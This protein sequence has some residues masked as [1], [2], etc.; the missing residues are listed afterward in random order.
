M[1]I[2]SNDSPESLLHKVFFEVGLHFGRRGREGWRYLRKYLFCFKRDNS[3]PNV[4]YVTLNFHES[5]KKNHGIERMHEKDQR[6][7]STPDSDT[8]PVNSLALYLSKLNPNSDAFL[9]IPKKNI[10]QS[11]DIWYPGVLGK[12][13]NTNMMKTIS[14]KAGLTEDYTN[15]CIRATTSTVL[16]NANVEHNDIISVTGHKDPKSLLP[17]IRSCSNEKRREMSTIL[18]N[19]GREEKSR[20]NKENE[21]TPAVIVEANDSD[22]SPQTLCDNRKQFPMKMFESNSITGGTFNINFNIK[23]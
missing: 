9:Q 4:R 18:N 3:N 8:C 22:E 21:I 6:M 11:E 12:N 16:A 5:T 13:T 7:Y 2:H 20:S 10:P 14:K 23:N 17:Y 15:H 1:K 19:Y